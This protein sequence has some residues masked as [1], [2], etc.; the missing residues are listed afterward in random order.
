MTQCDN[1]IMPV[2]IVIFFIIWEAFI[3]S[4][5]LFAFLFWFFSAKKFYGA[6]GKKKLEDHIPIIVQGFFSVLLFLFTSYWTF[7]LNYMGLEI[8]ITVEKIIITFAGP[9][10]SILCAWIYFSKSRNRRFE[11]Y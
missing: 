6:Q 2:G 8:E 10:L 9:L 11:L 4:I 1:E 5:G 7:Y 3:F